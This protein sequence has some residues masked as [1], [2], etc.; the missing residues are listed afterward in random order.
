VDT[1][2]TCLHVAGNVAI[3]GVT[4]RLLTG[5]QFVS[6]AGLVRITDAGGPNSGQDT[7]EDAT[8]S[9]TPTGPPIPG[10]TT[11]SSFT[12]SGPT[13][14]NSLGDFVVTDSQAL[15][16]FKEQCKNGGWRTFGETFK[17]QGQCVAF[18][19]RGSQP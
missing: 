12:P 4:G 15:P 8:R 5:G 14:V 3:I 7:F 18:V 6:I 2:V 17:N 1:E 11:C 19:Q 10:P 13:F 16:T 9:G